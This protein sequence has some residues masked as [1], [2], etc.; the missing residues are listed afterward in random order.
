MVE[1][2]RF[3]SIELSQM[4][5]QTGHISSRLTGEQATSAQPF[6]RSGALM[7]NRG[8]FG[9]MGRRPFRSKT[10][11]AQPHSGFTLLELL[12][13][14]AIIVVMASLTTF[15]IMNF[16]TNANRDAALSQ[17]ST[18]ST[19]CKMYKLN[20][21]AFPSSLNDLIALPTGM[22]Q[23]QWRG[24]YLDAQQV[25][26]DPW[27]QPYVMGANTGERVIISS[28]GPDLQAGTPDDISNN[29]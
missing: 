10:R 13:V 29:T 14:M 19:A 11:R 9:R 5:E 25:P 26:L 1:I 6:A 23:N 12:L 27:G 7:L 21:G 4:P 17:I 24:P 15:A 28:N 18:L 3:T 20:V 8:Q 16:R 22:N 2:C